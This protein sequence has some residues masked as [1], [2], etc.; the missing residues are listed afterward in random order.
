MKRMLPLLLA[1]LLLLTACGKSPAP[2]PEPSLLPEST[3]DTPEA[4]PSPTEEPEEDELPIL[5]DDMAVTIPTLSGTEVTLDGLSSYLR[6][7]LPEGWTWE[8]AGG[9]ENGTVYTL[10]PESDPDFK[11]E[12]RLWP[13]GFAMC[14]TGVTMQ[15]YS[16]PNGSKATLAY[17]RIGEEIAW[18]LILPQSPDSFTV[19]FNVPYALYEAHRE[20]LELMLSTIRLGV[21]AQ[22]NAVEPV[23]AAG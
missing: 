20:E 19:Q 23:T 11:V 8:Q 18:T 7:T 14:G 21:L 6:V 16:L 10:Y 15:D 2:Q 1:A 9:V 22:T 12:L 13:E 4:P 5:G 17:E 3:P